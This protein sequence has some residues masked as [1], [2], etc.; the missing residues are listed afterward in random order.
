MSSFSDIDWIV[1]EL[2]LKLTLSVDVD[3]D[4]D[5]G[6]SDDGANAE[7]VME[8]DNKISVLIIFNVYLLIYLSRQ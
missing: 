2:D 8:E 4:D 1:N 3:D 5:A 7:A 6:E